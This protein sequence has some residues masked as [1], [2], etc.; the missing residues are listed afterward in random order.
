MEF[1]GQTYT[2]RPLRE[3]CETDSTSMDVLNDWMREAHEMDYTRY[4][5][6]IVLRTPEGFMA[7]YAND[8]NNIEN[9]EP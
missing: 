4:Y 7:C 9:F 2:F 8:P 3:M 5:S 6:Y 1:Q